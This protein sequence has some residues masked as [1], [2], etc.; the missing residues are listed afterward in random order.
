M[1]I[2]IHGTCGGYEILTPEKIE[3]LDARPDSNKIKAIGQQAYSINFKDN[4]IIYSKYKIIRDELAD[5]RT[6]NIAFSIILSNTKK[7]SGENIIKLLDQLTEIFSSRHII[8][9]NL[10][11]F[12][13]D[14]SFV[15]N[16]TKEYEILLEK[17]IPPVNIE[18]YQGG[19]EDSAFIYYSDTTKLQEYFNYPYLEE[20]CKYKQ[21]FFVEECLSGK[22]ESPLNALR[23]NPN[24]DLTG[25]IKV[26]NRRYTLKNFSGNGN[27]GIKIEIWLIDNN[28]VC[29]NNDKIFKYDNIRL[30]YSKSKYFKDIDIKGK[31]EDIDISKYLKIQGED[32]FVEK[33]VAL[34]IVEK[35]ITLLVV[36]P[37]GKKVENAE[38]SCKKENSYEPKT[39]RNNE[40]KF[41][42]DE[43]NERWVISAK[44][45][46]LIALPILF[47]PEDFSTIEINLLEQK[48]LSFN[49]IDENKNTVKYFKIT[50]QHASK[51]IK[52]ENNKIIFFGNTIEKQW[53]VVVK[54]DDFEEKSFPITPRAQSG[55]TIPIPLIKRKI[56]P[57]NEPSRKPKIIIEDK[58]GKNTFKGKPIEL[59]KKGNPPIK[60]DT[61]FGY[62]FKSWNTKK[63]GNVIISHE[64]IF[65]ELW[66]LKIPKFVW[67][68]LPVIGVIFI[69]SYLLMTGE[70]KDLSAITTKISEY[71]E[72]T[73]LNK[74]TLESYKK[75]YCNVAEKSLWQT[76]LPFGS[77]ND[78]ETINKL[79][80]KIDSAIA[81]RVAISAGKIDDLKN[82]GYYD[83]QQ[84]FKEA[85]S[86][87]NDKYKKQIT[88]SLIARK[89]EQLKLDE[90]VKI[91]NKIQSGNSENPKDENG[92]E[93]ASKSGTNLNNNHDN[94][95]TIPNTVDIKPGKETQE[96]KLSIE[97]WALVKGGNNQKVSYDAILNK[98]KNIN[99]PIITYLKIICKDSENFRKFINIEK[100]DRENAN[101]L[102]DINLD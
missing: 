29:E 1:K 92:S 60:C 76:I 83:K 34:E 45:D 50:I 39:A 100:M 15:N 55:N 99:D 19:K 51:E 91:I 79:S 20:Y 59:D 53:N 63:E 44:K 30:K 6:G 84:P 41:E 22:D 18:K 3:M 33:N 52:I 17:N 54:S 86:S 71:V 80:S 85:I 23:H 70:N 62:K 48:I 72:G 74:D 49:F 93:E 37:K 66:F 94:N 10:N 87:V 13:E 42:G 81:L 75:Q 21:I 28:K 78:S 102:N 101:S 95:N 24:A 89:A 88:D 12:R 25:E 57:I 26:E 36:D 68:L 32:I 8:Y 97:F 96:S 65:T 35:I 64:A 90:I 77:D 16:L 47:N 27:N 73:E 46:D 58:K 7:L 67:I 31:I 38:I 82:I 98:Y 11:S 56:P 40:I 2:V 5:K 4:N 43:I 61:K 14:W 9:N 69:I